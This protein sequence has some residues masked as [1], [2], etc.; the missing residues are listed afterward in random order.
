MLA[1]SNPA[2]FDASMLVHFRERI[3]VKLVNKLNQE[4]LKQGLEIKEEEVNSKKSETEDSKS[5][6]T[7]RWK[8]ILDTSCAPADISYPTDLGLLYQA[9][10]QTEKTIDTLYNSLEVKNINKPKTYR[11]IARKNYSVVAKKRKKA[12]KKEAMLS[13]GNR[14]ISK[15]T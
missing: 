8:L 11:K 9:R 2:L 3:D 10:K 13:K 14:N 1:Y 12:L 7:N 15:D 6:S 4:I 5:E